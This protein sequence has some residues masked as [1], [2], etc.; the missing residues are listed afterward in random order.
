M[1]NHWIVLNYNQRQ[2]ATFAQ[3]DSKSLFIYSGDLA[4]LTL[5]PGG[6]ELSRNICYANT[7]VA[8]PTVV[9]AYYQISNKHGHEK[10][11]NWAENFLNIPFNLVVFTDKKNAWQPAVSAY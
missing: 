2:L 5:C 8:P 7:K 3:H 6:N 4:P 1:P 10:Y 9:T 11:L